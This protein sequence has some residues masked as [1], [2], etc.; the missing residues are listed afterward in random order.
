MGGRH[1]V[2]PT[3]GFRYIWVLS[4]CNGDVCLSLYP[5]PRLLFKS[6][7]RVVWLGTGGS[8]AQLGLQRERM[9]LQCLWN[10][11][12]LVGVFGER[13]DVTTLCWT[14]YKYVYMCVH[15]QAHFFR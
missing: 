14:V 13:S 7:H 1:G 2:T 12:M 3:L 11:V 6:I 8:Q 15:I 4:S 9:C 5:S 10:I